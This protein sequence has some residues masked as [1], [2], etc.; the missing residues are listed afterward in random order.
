MPQQN[1]RPMAES[2]SNVKNK[3]G[4]KHWGLFGL[5]WGIAVVGVVWVVSK[6]TL[7]DQALVVLNARTHRPQMV[8]LRQ[9][10]A[11]NAA[12]FNV[13]DPVD[14]SK[15]IVVPRSDV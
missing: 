5:R 12:V 3:K 6:M 13:V 11:E 15:T 14:T 1:Q 9:S 7:H 4:L 2:S 8:S 10:A